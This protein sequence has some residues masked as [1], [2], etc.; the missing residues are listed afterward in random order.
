MNDKELA[1]LLARIQVLDNRQV[2]SIVLA[3][4]KDVIGDLDYADSVTAVNT[5][6]RRSTE[7][8]KPA[9]IFEETRQIASERRHKKDVVD[10]NARRELEN[11]ERNESYVQFAVGK[12]V[13]LQ[14][15][16]THQ[17]ARDMD[18]LEERDLQHCWVDDDYREKVL[19]MP[20]Q[21]A[22]I[23]SKQ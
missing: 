22:A 14:E 23:G 21:R 19:N 4:W 20:R 8:L 5:H 1:Q 12:G 3:M 18:W 13:T 16:F 6:F 9:H 2:D 7:Y 15:L 10:R 17:D 11:R